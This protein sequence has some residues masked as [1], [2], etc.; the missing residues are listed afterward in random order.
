MYS[1]NDPA[2]ESEISEKCSDF[3]YNDIEFQE[4]SHYQLSS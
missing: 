3:D 1:I 4:G 2:G